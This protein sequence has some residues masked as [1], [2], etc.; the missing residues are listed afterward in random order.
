MSALLSCKKLCD[1]GRAVLSERRL[2]QHRGP[3]ALIVDPEILHLQV[4]QAVEKACLR[5][6]QHV[7][8]HNLRNARL[9]MHGGQSRGRRSTSE[10]ENQLKDRASGGLRA[11]QAV[12]P[13]EGEV[14]M[15]DASLSRLVQM[16][17]LSPT[18]GLHRRERP[19]LRLTSNPLRLAHPARQLKPAASPILLREMCTVRERRRCQSPSIQ[20]AKRCGRLS[21]FTGGPGSAEACSRRARFGSPINMCC[22]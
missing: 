3:R 11:D 13:G 22:A 21:V 6:T 9:E 7:A 18:E 1:T 15:V 16:G 10:S 8:N 2:R 14:G 20:K 4:A 17:Y 5:L 19:M 12:G